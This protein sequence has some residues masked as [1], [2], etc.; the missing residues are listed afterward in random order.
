M[1]IE[2]IFSSSPRGKENKQ[3]KD[4]HPDRGKY[5]LDKL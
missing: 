4:K 3:T 1:I 5:F 2:Y